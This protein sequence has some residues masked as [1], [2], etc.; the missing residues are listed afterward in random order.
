M[1]RNQYVNRIEYAIGLWIAVVGVVLLIAL[2]GYEW[3]KSSLEK[4]AI[5]AYEKEISSDIKALIEAQ[6]DAS[7][8]IALTL[9]ENPDIK[10]M[11]CKTCA[12][13]NFDFKQLSDQLTV[14]T[15]F[16]NV[17]LQLV[18]SE[19]VS[20]LRSW[21]PKKGD[22]LLRVRQYIR[23]NLTNPKVTRTLSVGK[24]TLSVKSAVPIF[25][26]QQKFI[27]LVEVI[28]TFGNLAERLKQ[29]K[30]IDSVILAD[31]RF[32]KQ[33]SNA[34]TNLFI[35]DYYVVNKASLIQDRTFLSELAKVGFTHFG[36]YLLH[37]QT[38]IGRHL[39][40]DSNSQEI[41]S[42]F[43]FSKINEVDFTEMNQILAGYIYAVMLFLLLLTVLFIIYYFKRQSDGRKHYYRQIIDSAS[44]IIL[45][46][47]RNKVVDANQH[48]F[49]F[50]SDFS[51][52]AEFL[53]KQ[54]DLSH[55][56]EKK[57]G[58][59]QKYIQG[60]YWL[61]YVLQN[62]KKVHKA[63]IMKDGQP[64]Y[65]SVKAGM[66]KGLQKPLFNVLLQEITEQELYKNQLEHLSQTDALTGIGNRLHFNRSLN[67]EIQ[68]S[69]RYKS[70]LSLL[71]FDIDFFKKVNDNYGHDV[72][73]QVLV[74]ISTVMQSLL[75]ET[76]ILCRFGGE[77]FA[78]I[79][80]ETS[81]VEAETSAERFRATIEKI[82][83]DE[84]PS[85]LTISFGVGQVTE[86]DNEKTILK[87]VDNALYSAKELG[88]NR[89]V[90]AE[91]HVIERT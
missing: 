26:E 27:G 20:L 76:D 3:G 1:N 43:T 38:I 46:A 54:E 58:F 89:V 2:W 11:L 70:A 4:S 87:R 79:M 72:G 6:K 14:N 67:K 66:M 40:Q 45:V 31:K 13:I 57:E 69:H 25:N 8:A 63:K 64:H 73:D 84:F 48:F 9:S 37:G 91:S 68:R 85:K 86:W 59:L 24:F 23:D 61:D 36:D 19:G 90:V 83:T 35:E 32:R 34:E 18:D 56:F 75:S 74:K 42:W 47:D 12:P 53:E 22:S 10:T 71:I 41:A 16:N 80:P 78:I 15:N 7:M 51:T 30:D 29:A 60:V 39:I 28:S 82:S 5:S 44:D 50:Y 17:W 55:T 21:S 81:L 77:E 52:L 33:L 49:D 65:F 62:R 88:R